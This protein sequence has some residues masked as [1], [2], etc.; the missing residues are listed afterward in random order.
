[1]HRN[2]L[3]G[4]RVGFCW[5]IK[6]ASEKLLLNSS[7]VSV[8]TLDVFMERKMWSSKFVAGGFLLTGAILGGCASAPQI[9]E[10]SDSNPPQLTATGE[11]DKSGRELLTWDRPGAF[12]KVPA[13]KKVLGNAACL[14]ARVDLEAIGYHPRAKD[15]AGK[16]MPG[17]GFFCAIKAHGDKPSDTP[18]RLVR[19]NAVLGWDNPAAFGAVPTDVKSRGDAICRQAGAQLE[20]VGYHPQARNEQNTPIVGGGFFCGPRKS[21]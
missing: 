6:F 14:L 13:D 9:G 5:V 20:A 12:G 1:M 2:N 18:P 8:L 19:T 7:D 3:L 4:F 11:R 16:E 10:A 15:G 17:G 21:V